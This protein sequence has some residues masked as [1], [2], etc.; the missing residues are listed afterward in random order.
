MTRTALYR[1]FDRHDD[2]L[3]VGISIAPLHRWTQHKAD[4]PWIEDV[5]STSIEWYAT[6]AEAL[7]AE[8]RAIIEERP[9]HN[10]THNTGRPA[11][12][13]LV[14][15]VCSECGEIIDDGDGWIEC[16]VLAAGARLATT[17][18][19]IGSGWE[20]IPW[21]A[22]HSW[23]DPD[24]DSTVPEELRDFH[25]TYYFDVSEIRTLAG[26]IRWTSHLYGK[27]W[28]TETD[29]DEV[30]ERIAS[31]DGIIRMDP[32]VLGLVP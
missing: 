20:P 28:V 26:L 24:I 29:W 21:E 14:T 31:G 22:R 2:L 11:Q 15:V 19:V 1:F 3:Y 10:I 25:E 5:A 13:A 30:L 6:R 32:A 18:Q 4:K 9:R 27:A 12:P 16:D 7:E 8:R 23:C 17:V